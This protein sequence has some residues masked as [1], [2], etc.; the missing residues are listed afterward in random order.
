MQTKVKDET[1]L[2][3]LELATIDLTITALQIAGH[4]IDDRAKDDN[5]RQQMA[6][7]WADAH[8]PLIELTERDREIIKQIKLL[9]GQLSGRT[10]LPELLTARGEILRNG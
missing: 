6:E 2:S 4:N 1:M 5:P 8:H 10:T 9:A 3:H 7:G